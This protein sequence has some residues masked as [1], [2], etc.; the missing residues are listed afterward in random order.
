MGD[1]TA[2]V[3]GPAMEHARSS[4]LDGHAYWSPGAAD[5]DPAESHGHNVP[6]VG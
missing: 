6:M 2:A 1:H 5:D 3:P 4:N